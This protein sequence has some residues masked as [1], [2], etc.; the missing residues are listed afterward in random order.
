VLW[1]RCL[2]IVP[3]AFVMNF[4]NSLAVEVCW[5]NPFF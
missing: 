2:V 5:W 4:V 3:R 1:L